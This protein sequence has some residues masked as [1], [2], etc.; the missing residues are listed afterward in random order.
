[1]K[2]HEAYNEWSAT[3][4]ADENATRDLDK[5]V[6]E[7]SLGK[8]RFGSIVEAGCGT[9]KNTEFLLK[10]GREIHALD[11]SK[12]MIAKAQERLKRRPQVKFV[13]ADLSKRWPLSRGT[14]DLVTF[15]LVLEHVDELSP[16]FGEA[17]RVLVKGGRM[18]ISELHPFRQYQAKGANYRRGKQTMTITAFVHHLSDFVKSAQEAGFVLENFAE[19]WH[20]KDKGKTPRLVSLLFKRV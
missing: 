19:W 5:T 11:F 10:I 13:H 3:Y 14:A 12:G 2:V 18:F 8:L 15:N 1:M 16:V 7:R 17:A 20:A 9:G 4:D 6:V